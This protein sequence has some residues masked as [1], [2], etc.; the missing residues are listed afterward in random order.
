MPVERVFVFRVAKN[1]SSVEGSLPWNGQNSGAHFRTHLFSRIVL[2]QDAC[3]GCQSRSCGDENQYFEPRLHALNGYRGP[4]KYMV[5]G[6]LMKSGRS[7]C[8]YQMASHAAFL[9]NPTCKDLI[10]TVF[11]ATCR[12]LDT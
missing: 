5:A 7:T 8:C 2:V 10:N 9:R 3:S 6:S 4:R 12:C 1:E 11:T